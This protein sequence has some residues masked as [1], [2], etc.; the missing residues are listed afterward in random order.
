[1]EILANPTDKSA[2]WMTLVLRGREA[3][4]ISDIFQEIND[5]N[6]ALGLQ[7]EDKLLEFQKSLAQQP[8]EAR[9]FKSLEVGIIEIRFMDYFL[10]EYEDR[11]RH[12]RND[13]LR[14][15]RV[16]ELL[17]SAREIEN[18]RSAVAGYVKELNQQ[19]AMAELLAGALIVGRLAE[20][21][22]IIDS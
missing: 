9:P 17:K 6:V 10:R 4:D 22:V 20:S 8:N 2:K 12:Q 1:M 3:Y 11:L 14:H 16:R 19:V 18:R 13:M 7:D 21:S 5:R 15:A